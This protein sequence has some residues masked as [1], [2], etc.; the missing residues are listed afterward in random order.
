M[1]KSLKL[2]WQKCS[3][4]QPSKK[5]YQDKRRPFVLLRWKEVCDPLLQPHVLREGL[6]RRGAASSVLR[7]QLQRGVVVALPCQ[8][9]AG[10]DGCVLL[11]QN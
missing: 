6:H 1:P 8:G 7:Q 4:V 10:G 9:L 2:G 11:A 5:L 3:A